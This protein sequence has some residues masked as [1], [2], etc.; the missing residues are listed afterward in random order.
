[1]SLL[2][3]S[4]YASAWR[5]PAATPD[6]S[7]QSGGDGR[8]GAVGAGRFVRLSCRSSR[9]ARRIRPTRSLGSR[10]SAHWI[11]PLRPPHPLRFR[12]VMAR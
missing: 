6:A 12:H 1:M 9:L 11:A 2:Y 4:V 3:F 7:A 10:L 5:R 8:C